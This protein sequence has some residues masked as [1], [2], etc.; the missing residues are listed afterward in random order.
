MI[1]KDL[2]AKL[3]IKGLNIDNPNE[4][5]TSGLCTDLLSLV[6]GNS[7]KGGV[8]VTHQGH[9]NTIAVALLAELAAVIV[10]GEV[11]ENTIKAAKDKSV[12]LF[13]S[14][15]TAFDLVGKLY[16]L[17]IGPNE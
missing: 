15:T 5:I 9:V 14:D 13:Y 8:W 17:G 6:I 12:N 1:V 3:P 2:A 16:T 11:D 7:K 4:E 10:L